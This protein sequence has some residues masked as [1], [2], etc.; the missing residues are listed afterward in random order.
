MFNIKLIDRRNKPPDESINKIIE[1]IK[2][3]DCALK[4]EFIERYRPYIVK[5]VSSTIG[6]Y[7]HSEESEEYSIGLMAFNEAIDSFNPNMNVNFFK[8]CSV[9]INHRIIDYIRKDKRSNRMLPFSYLE[10]TDGFEEKYL[11]SDSHYQYEK[12]EFKE[13]VLLL[14]KQLKEFG[15]T[16]EDLVAASP[17]HRDSRE[18][19]ISI[20]R[21]LADN[22]ILYDKMMRKKCIPLSDLMRLVKVNKKTVERNRKYIIAVSLVL[23]SS[24][25]DI[26][27]FFRN[28]GEGG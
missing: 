15:I 21:V 9:V 1:K 14:E 12:I 6:K 26:K 5:I 4:E 7:I 24:F 13:E 19:Y 22:K 17:K 2:N 11:I 16:F 28:K 8:Y 10:N 23:G 27:E 3:G 18:L 20:A 25:E